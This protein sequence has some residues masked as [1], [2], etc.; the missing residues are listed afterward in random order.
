MI[1][2]GVITGPV[3]VGKST[4]L[5]EADTLL[6]DAGIPHASLEL[7][8]IAR[9]WGRKTSMSGNADIAYRNLASVWTNYSV[10][11]ADK[12]LLTMLM[13]RR[14]DLR[15][16]HMAIR[17]AD[18]R[19]VR[20]HAPLPL[21]EHRLRSREKTTPDQEV[22]AAQWWFARLKGSRF[23][24]HVIANDDRSPKE[25]ALEVLRALQWLD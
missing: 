2:V 10:A 13:E 18:I 9:Y 15:P 7:E 23:A 3:G 5:Q 16:L 1:R 6:I 25:V 24:D 12:L 17:Q 20:L 8:A 22:S 14:S 19:V 21:I 11:G 4:V